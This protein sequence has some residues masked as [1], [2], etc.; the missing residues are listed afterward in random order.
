MLLFFGTVVL[1]MGSPAQDRA[2]S[3]AFRTDANLTLVNA[4]VVDQEFIL[5]NGVWAK[6]TNVPE[7]GPMPRRQ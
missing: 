6:S 5:G 1:A 7:G 4:S 2:D 3:P